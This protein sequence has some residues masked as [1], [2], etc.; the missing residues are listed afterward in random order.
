MRLTALVLLAGCAALLVSAQELDIRPVTIEQL[1]RDH[2]ELKKELAEKIKSTTNTPTTE[3]TATSTADTSPTTATTSTV[4]DTTTTSAPQADAPSAPAESTTP[5]NGERRPG[6]QPGG[7]RRQASA[8][9]S[10]RFGEAP[11][12]LRVA[13]K[14]G[15]EAANQPQRRNGRQ[16]PGTQ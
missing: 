5:T 14:D 15:S 12:R 8:K 4:P 11:H 6:R 13:A 3:E 9:E 10:Q 16:F 1:L 7:R 2:P